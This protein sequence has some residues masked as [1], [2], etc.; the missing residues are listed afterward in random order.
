MK[1]ILFLSA[2]DFKEKSIQ[3]IRN[4]PL[5]YSQYGWEVDYV[6]MRDNSQTGSYY[7]EKELKPEGVNVYRGYW[8][9][10]KLLNIQGFTSLIARKA[11]GM[12]VSVKLY[13]KAASLIK[14]N[15]Y[16]VIYGYEYHGVWAAFLI[17]LLLLRKSKK[18][19]YVS[20]YM[21]TWLNHYFES[22]KW[23]KLFFSIDQILSFKCQH[24]ICIMTDDGTQG[25]V[26]YNKFNKDNDKLRFWVNGVKDFPRREVVLDKEINFLSISRLHDWKR[27]DRCLQFFAKCVNDYPHLDL[28]YTIVG[29]GRKRAELE[30]LS[31]RL[32][33]Q[34]Q[35][36]FVGG[37]DN[38]SVGKYLYEADIFLSFYDLS[39]VGNPL[40]ESISAGK[41]IFT[42][43]NGDTS[44]WIN[45]KKNGFI[46]SP[47]NFM[48]G[49]DDFGELVESP[50][51]QEKSKRTYS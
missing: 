6:V 34:S 28:S 5:A 27:V 37:V 48:K 46:Y 40:L 21:G 16:N 31:E 18:V 38:K 33:I 50:D 30:S 3:I 39:N 26:I 7:Y 23:L 44:R 36:N 22:K 41:I 51:L 19:V 14:E 10:K 2:N 12:L 42:L 24:D 4:T 35:V 43:N 45:H 13:K 47:S 32:G 11:A 1:K 17:R 20:R 9:L 15:D 49:V 25:D 29:E 8:P